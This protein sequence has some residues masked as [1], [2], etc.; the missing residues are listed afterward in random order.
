MDTWSK[1]TQ[2]N[3]IYGE[4]VEPTNPILSAIA[5][6]KADLT[7]FARFCLTYLAQP[8]HFNTPTPIFTPKINI[9]ILKKLKNPI[10]SLNFAR[11]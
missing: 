6:A 3:P 2:S 8:L 5:S 7:F 4:P 9:P 1:Q 10:F 11:Q